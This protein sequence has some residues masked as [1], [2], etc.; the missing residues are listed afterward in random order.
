MEISVVIPVHNK[1]V[2]DNSGASKS[3]ISIDGM[4]K[5]ECVYI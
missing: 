3:K 4:G 1:R 5:K 2:I